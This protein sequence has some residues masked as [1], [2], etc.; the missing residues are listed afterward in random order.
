MSGMTAI[1]HKPQ[2]QLQLR[3]RKHFSRHMLPP[4]FDSCSILLLLLLCLYY[5]RDFLHHI[6]TDTTSN[7]KETKN[8]MTSVSKSSCLL[9]VSELH[10]REVM[11][12]C[13]I[14][15]HMTF[16]DHN[17]YTIHYKLQGCKA[18]AVLL[19]LNLKKFTTIANIY[20]W[21]RY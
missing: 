5:F 7:L 14:C 16:I 13:L 8:C 6:S 3:V 2:T 10:T 11:N 1:Y 18:L 19:T 15:D 4:G 21:L 17:C 20:Y 9:T 12:F